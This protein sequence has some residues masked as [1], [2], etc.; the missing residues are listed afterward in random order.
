MLLDCNN[1]QIFKNVVYLIMKISKFSKQ[2][3]LICI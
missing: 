1:F 2:L 3:D